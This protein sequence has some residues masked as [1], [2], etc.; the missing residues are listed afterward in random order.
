MFISWCG[1]WRVWGDGGGLNIYI[2]A[3]NMLLVCAW[4]YQI[5]YHT[6][7]KLCINI[8]GTYVGTYYVKLMAVERLWVN[9]VICLT[10]STGMNLDNILLNL[11]Y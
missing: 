1:V 5:S 9:Y 2:C 6:R 7:I 8:I 10:Q 4:I 11:D 3:H